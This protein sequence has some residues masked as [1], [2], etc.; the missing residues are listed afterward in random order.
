MEKSISSL[1]A[2]YINDIDLTYEIILSQGKGKPTDKL[3]NMLYLIS[4]KV[5]TRFSYK[6]EEDRED[7]ISD[8]FLH[9]TYQYKNFNYNKYKKSLP[10]ITEVTKRKMSKYYNENLKFKGITGNSKFKKDINGWY[11]LSNIFNA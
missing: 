4:N 1:M 9:L 2:N 5:N 3:F 7:V 10:Y 8:A 11:S 6:T